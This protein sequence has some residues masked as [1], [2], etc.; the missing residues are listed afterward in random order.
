[1]LNLNLN[2]DETFQSSKKDLENVLEENKSLKRD[3]AKNS[4][5]NMKYTE[6]IDDLEK[7]LKEK[8]DSIA[9]LES[10]LNNKN[11]ENDKLKEDIKNL[12]KMLFL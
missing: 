9:I 2:V 8:D 6:K 3:L 10:T 12:K 5:S 4:N 11:F 1:M 7:E